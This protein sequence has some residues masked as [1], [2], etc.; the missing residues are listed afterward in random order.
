MRASAPWIAVVVAACS[1][2]SQPAGKKMPVEPKQLIEQSLEAMGGGEKLRNLRTIQIEGPMHT[3]ALDQP[4]RFNTGVLVFYSR[5]KDVVD[6]ADLKFRRDVLA[7]FPGASMTQITLVNDRFTVS[8]MSAGDYQPPW[9]R[10]SSVL[11]E[12]LYLNPI[13]VLLTA[14]QASDLRSEVS[15]STNPDFQLI[16]TWNKVPVHLTIDRDS[17]LPRSVELTRPYPIDAYQYWGDVTTRNEFHF[18]ELFPGGVKYPRRIDVF[19]NGELQRQTT[20]EKLLLEPRVETTDFEISAEVKTQ[21]EPK[22]PF[23]QSSPGPAKQIGPDMHLLPGGWNVTLVRQSDGVVVIEAPQSSAYSRDVLEAINKLYP[24]SHVKAVVSTGQMSHYVAG[25]REYVAGGIPVYATQDTLDEI[26]KMLAA[27]FISEPDTLARHPRQPVLHVVDQSITLGSGTT[28][29]QL[30]PNSAEF[31]RLAVFFPAQKLLYA[32]DVF[33]RQ[34]TV[35]DSLQ[36]GT[37][38]RA[39]LFMCTKFAERNGINVEKVYGMH[40]EPFPYA[41]LTSVVNSI[42]AGKE[43]GV[44][45]DGH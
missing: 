8:K 42:V 37:A 12:L 3:Y 2:F 34:T 11:S 13:H 36:R 9:A 14:S 7:Q 18:W 4:E 6:F 15:L 23:R 20:C 1:A 43:T 17:L 24:G 26:R 21:P 5:F 40:L 28:A 39:E 27:K 41:N 33:F 30:I 25:I 31:S 32:S 38:I 29:I 19:Q 44:Q 35:K 45:G 22:S 16:F 10:Q